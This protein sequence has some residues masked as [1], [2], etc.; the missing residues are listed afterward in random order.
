LAE[1]LWLIKTYAYSFF[2]CIDKGKESTSDLDQEID[3]REKMMDVSSGRGRMQCVPS[4]T[5]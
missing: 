4:L 1:F 3:F 2:V 5:D